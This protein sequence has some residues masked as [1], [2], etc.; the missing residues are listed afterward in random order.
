[1]CVGVG[2][3]SGEHEAVG[4]AHQGTHHTGNLVDGVVDE[5]PHRGIDLGHTGGIGA[6][7]PGP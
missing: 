3:A 6:S 7:A 5:L 1:M 4:A 2:E